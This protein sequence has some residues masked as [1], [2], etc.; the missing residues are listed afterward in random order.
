M[1]AVWDLVS[2]LGILVYV[3]TGRMKHLADA[4]LALWS[5]DDDRDNKTASVLMA[6]LVLQWAW[7]RLITAVDPVNHWQDAVYS[8]WLEGSLVAAAVFVGRM[9]RGS[10]A[11]V[12]ALCIGCAG[13]VMADALQ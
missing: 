6:C 3:G 5:T 9:H 7:M 4:H 10:G 12:V 2:G 8:Y 11:A 1:N 13:A